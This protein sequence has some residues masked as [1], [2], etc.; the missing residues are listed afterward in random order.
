SIKQTYLKEYF[1]GEFTIL[2]ESEMDRISRL[3]I[4]DI[5]KIELVEELAGLSPEER[6]EFLKEMEN[7]KEE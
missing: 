7:V 5:E 3:K 4:S 6:E 1:Q 2:S